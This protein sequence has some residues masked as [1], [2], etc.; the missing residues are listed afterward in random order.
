[1]YKVLEYVRRLPNYNE[2]HNAVDACRERLKQWKTAMDEA[3]LLQQLSFVPRFRCS[4]TASAS[5]LFHRCN[6]LVRWRRVMLRTRCM[7][8][9]MRLTHILD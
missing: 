8:L 5:V 2:P 4:T 1:M 3:G 9:G 6:C 7:S